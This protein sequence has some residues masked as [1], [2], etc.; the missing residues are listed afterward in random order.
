MIL[1]AHRGVTSV[2]WSEVQTWSPARMLAAQIV[3]AE[4]NGGKWNPAAWEVEWPT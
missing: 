2:P 3:V 4:A 1:L